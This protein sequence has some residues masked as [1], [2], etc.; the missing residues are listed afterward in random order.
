[1]THA[2]DTARMAHWETLSSE[3]KTHAVR[4]LAAR[5]GFGRYDIS[6]ATGLSVEQIDQVLEQTAQ[7]SAD[8]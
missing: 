5:D 6:A 3:Q 1:M 7:T 2:I 4:Q 8:A